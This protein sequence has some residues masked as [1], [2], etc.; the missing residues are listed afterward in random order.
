MLGGQFIEEAYGT[1]FFYGPGTLPERLWAFGPPPADVAEQEAPPQVTGTYRPSTGDFDGDGLTDIA[2][3][4]TEPEP[5]L[6]V[7]V[8]RHGR[9]HAA[10]APLGPGGPPPPSRWADRGQM[11]SAVATRRR[12][13]DGVAPAPAERLA[14]FRYRWRSY[15]TV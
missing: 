8:R 13:Q 9:R 12:C 2:W 5:A 1:L 6:V 4:A 11:P 15:S 7:P 14:R 10:A 3:V